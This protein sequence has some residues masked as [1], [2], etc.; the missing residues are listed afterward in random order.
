M[1]ATTVK[2]S[3]QNFFAQYTDAYNKALSGHL[4][5]PRL[6]SF[7]T[8][9]F[10]A[11]GPDSVNAGKNDF[12]FSLGLRKAY[13]FYRKIGTQRLGIRHLEITEIDD[14]HDMVKVFYQ[15]DYLKDDGTPVALDFAVT[16]F[17]QRHGD[18]IKIFSFVAGDEMQ[19]YK[20]AGLV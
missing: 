17:L 19:A 8:D 11:A 9:Q 13:A 1:T 12:F 18:D 7:F 10:L 16:Y 2:A 15:A 6:R 14:F 4:H 3:Y 5:I 20:E